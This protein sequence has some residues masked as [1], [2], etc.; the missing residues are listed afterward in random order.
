M[1]TIAYIYSDPLLETPENPSIWGLEVDR[2]YQDIGDRQ[3]L[4]E[5]IKDCQKKPPQYLLIRSLEE[6]GE[7]IID[8]NNNIKIL[9][10]LL[11]EIIAIDQPYNSSQFKEINNQNTKDLLIEIL[12]QI[13]DNQRSR[14][15]RKGHAL[16]RLK[17]L[18][19]PGRSPYGY[20]RGKDKYIIDR[21]TAPVIKDFFERFLLYGSLRDAVR[22]LERK[23]G[24][25]IA[26]S[27]GRYW[28]T[29]PVYRG[30]LLYQNKQVIS[31]TH[32]PI[33][34]REEAAQIDRLLRRNSNFSA[35]SA[36]SSRS[37][38]GLVICGECQGKMRINRVT[39]RKKAGEY[40]YLTPLNCPKNP[41]CKSINYDLVLKETINKICN[42]LSIAIAKLNMPFPEVL[43]A[44]L[45][46]EISKKK[47]TIE[48]LPELIEK[49]I[50]DEET[51]Q[52]RTYKLRTEIATL[53]N[54]IAQLPPVN[55]KAIASTI[56][57]PQFWLDLSE[58]ERRFYFREFISKI[59]IIPAEND[60][61]KSWQIN[62][63]FI[64]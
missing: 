21:S 54:K 14:N 38:A 59:V 57:I 39:Q 36:S 11:I 64:F 48:K 45:Q 40:L 17:T 6:L 22:Y 53:Q 30:D 31:D 19:P 33:I 51:A 41:R 5:L 63:I 18:P 24:K 8:I 28:L 42:E 20:R 29:N 3:Q 23:Y 1:T 32:A 47:E 35:R 44:N 55:L 4:Q 56:T 49:D 43:K 37:L 25:K 2:V 58:T 34:N 10:S 46:A 13:Q 12:Q 26:V 62:L 27:T 15:L 7:S 50:L 61:H 16:N 9:E 60:D 52:I